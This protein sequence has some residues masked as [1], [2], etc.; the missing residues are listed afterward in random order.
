MN[1]IF[2]VLAAV[3]QASSATLDKFILSL[4]RV[5]FPHY[6]GVSFPLIFLI[7]LGI[8][9]VSRVGFPTEGFSGFWLILLALS[10]VSLVI[11]NIL[12]YRALDADYLSVIEPI[13]LVS[14]VPTILLAALIFSGERN[15]I[16]I[17]FGII[18]VLTVLWTNT[19]KGHLNFAKFSKPFFLYKLAVAPFG[20]VISLKLLQ[21]WNPIALQMIKNGFAALVMLFLFWHSLKSV[22]RKSFPF[23]LITNILTS[24][25]WILYYFSF[26]RLGIVQ[27]V[28]IFSIQPFLVYFFALIFLKEKFKKKSF[29]AFIIVLICISA[30]HFLDKV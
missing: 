17:I 26:Q 2:P 19:E 21:I 9:L 7:T 20:A 14:K 25:A 30:A 1:L 11:L 27:T 23:L 18:A 4:K 13:S 10:I 24:V 28:L 3:L 5:E 8:F 15:I 12:F 16:V 29:I 22:P 6:I